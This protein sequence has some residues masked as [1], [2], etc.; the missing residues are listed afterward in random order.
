MKNLKNKTSLSKKPDAGILAQQEPYEIIF[1]DPRDAEINL[2]F[3]KKS[4]ISAHMARWFL[5]QEYNQLI[6]SDGI[7]EILELDPRKFGANV[8]SFM[9]MVHPEDRELKQQA[10]ENLKKTFKPIELNY[11][12]LF[13]DNRI[14]WINEICN[15][16]FDQEGHPIRSYGTIQD[17]TKYK[18]IEENFRKKEDQFKDLIESIPS[19][20]AIIQNNKFTFFNP[21]A[22]KIFG[23]NTSDQFIGKTTSKIIHPQSNIL[24]SKK[25]KSVLSKHY[26]EVFEEK[27]LRLDGSLF[28]AEITLSPR[29]FHSIPSVL[30]IVNDITKR[31]KNEDDLRKSEEK[32][33][34]L[35]TDLSENENRLKDL[36]ATKDK[37]FSIIAHDLRSPFNSILGFIDLIQNQY[38]DIDDSEM[39]NY[40]HLIDDDTQKT[41]KLLENLLDWA[42]IQTGKISFKPGIQRLLPIIEN[43]E[44]ILKSALNVKQ[45][46][47]KHDISDQMEVFADTNMLTSILRNLISNSI[48][49]SHP[50][51]EITID[52]ESK[53]E[54][55]E[56]SISDAGTGMDEETR[57][58]LFVINGQVSAPGTE[59]ETG[60]GLGLILCKEFIEKHKGTIWVESIKGKGTKIVFRIPQVKF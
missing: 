10:Q 14:K 50:G 41:L 23:G 38:D 58:K 52:A 3:L 48:K 19:G 16:D 18:I 22:Q 25:I 45:L 53:N 57:K 42:K 26:D 15:T 1:A 55:I 9:E 37:F 27:L 7:F 33:R 59:N 11:R 51:G 46:L 13:E 24:F 49:Y 5:D 36:V 40:L 54:W 31:K 29:L 35:A 43:V 2:K 56:F 32:F 39:K 30:F 34:I 6:W 17:I 20:I 8:D 47:L 21:A 60:S 28:D 12:L 4:Q 44:E